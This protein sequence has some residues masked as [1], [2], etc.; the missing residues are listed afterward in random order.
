MKWISKKLKET[1]RVQSIHGTQI[2]ANNVQALVQDKV[3]LGTVGA[4]VDTWTRVSQT[5]SL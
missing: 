1:P 3:G 2:Q 4:G 5:L